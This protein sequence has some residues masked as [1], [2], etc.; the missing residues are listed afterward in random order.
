MNIFLVSVHT[1]S[2]EQCLERVTNSRP[3]ASNLHNLFS[4][5][6]SC[7]QELGKQVTHL[8]KTFLTANLDNYSNKILFE[9]TCLV[10]KGM[11]K[12]IIA[13][14]QTSSIY[15]IFSDQIKGFFQ[16]H[17]CNVVTQSFLLIIHI[18]RKHFLG[19]WGYKM[20]N[21]LYF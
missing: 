2:L 6:C 19:G 1:S 3:L 8:G 4:T 20:A 15:S 14:R 11:I 21:F 5:Y 13:S 16:K 9:V 10:D 18:L 12:H 7:S 17:N